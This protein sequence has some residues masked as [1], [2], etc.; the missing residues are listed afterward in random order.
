MTS[1]HFLRLDRRLSKLKDLLLAV[2]IPAMLDVTLFLVFLSDSQG[3]GV[4]D[5]GGDLDLFPCHLEMV[6]H[7]EDTYAVTGVSVP[8][9]LLLDGRLRIL[10]ADIKF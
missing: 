8:A 3:C 2:T 10:V 5:T 4:I 7:P 6:S 9:R 1:V